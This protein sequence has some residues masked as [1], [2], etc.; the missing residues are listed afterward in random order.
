MRRT[1]VLLALAT[2]A[3]GAVPAL[4]GTDALLPDQTVT[5]TITAPVP[6]N[7][8]GGPRRAALV[9]TGTNGLI[10]HYFTV[11]PST[12]GGTFDLKKGADPSGQ[13]D[14]NIIF[15]S[16]AGDVAQ[17]APT[18]VGEFSSAEVG[19]E[20]GL[21]PDGAK[22]G[23][24]FLSG[25]ARVG[26]DYK[27][28]PATTVAL[29]GA[30]LDATVAAGQPVRFVNDTAAPLTVVSDDVDEFDSP[31]FDTGELAPGGAASVVL[32]QPGTYAFTAGDR[33]G[34]LTVS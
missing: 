8:S 30:S 10:G 5:G 14:L 12:V 20:K 3:A 25:G 28:V 24:V 21:V 27:A 6:A 19:G 2:A 15:Y 33:T 13:G 4:A 7:V 32:T 17:T 11:D 34:T 22:N 26:F 31:L 29:S 16:N 9:S 18:I 23:L 1:A